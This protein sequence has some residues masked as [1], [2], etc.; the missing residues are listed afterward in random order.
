M[1]PVGTHFHEFAQGYKG[2]GPDYGKVDKTEGL[3]WS[4]FPKQ[5]N[6]S[7]HCQINKTTFCLNSK[8]N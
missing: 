3:L 2:T 4:T 1:T 5:H 7:N 8:I 6:K